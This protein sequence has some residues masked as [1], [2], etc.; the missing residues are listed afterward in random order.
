MDAENSSR[1]GLNGGDCYRFGTIV[2]DA[3][4][5][6]L[7]R[8]GKPQ[9]LEPKAFAV[10]LFLLQHAGE[11]VRHGDLLD[12]VWGHRHVTPGVLTR[13]IAQLRHALDD[14]SQ[15]P[16]YIQTQH[17]LG[18]RFVGELL[19]RPHAGE[20]ES[21][22]PVTAPFDSAPELPAIVAEPMGDTHRI[23]G[24][25][26]IAGDS[27]AASL[28]SARVTARSSREHALSRGLW[29]LAFLLALVLAVWL[30]YRQRPIS[31]ARSTDVSI[32]VLPFASLSDDKSDSYFAE[33][34]AV[35]L[36]DALAG[37][38][39][40]KVA[41]CRTDS[42]CG[43]RGADI[44]KIGKLLGVATVLDAEVRREGKRVRINAHLADTRTGF[45]LWSGSYD[46]EL[47]G[48][49][50]LQNDIA[51]EVVRSLPGIA[52]ANSDALARRLE[53][54]HNIVAYDA[55]LKGVQQ[56]TGR[57]DGAVAIGFFSEAL[58]ADPGFA[59]A[60]A[61]ICRGE[62]ITFESAHDAAAYDRA[63]AA[64]ERAAQMDPQLREVN[65]ALGD[66]HQ[67]R[68]E[69]AQ[70]IVYYKQALEDNALKPAAYLG[71]ARA[72]AAQQ[73]ND[74]AFQY[75]ERARQLRP[76]DAAIYRSL[77]F[78]HYVSGDLPKAIETYKI[79]TELEPNDELTWASYGGLC[80]ASGDTA[81]ASDAFMRSLAIKP[82]YGALIN[83]GTLRF[84]AGVYDE[85]ADLYRRAAEL[86]PSDYRIWG[87]L[88]DALSAIAAT[89]DQAR[90]PYKRA[91]QMAQSY[92]DIKPGD[93]HAIAV[94]AWYR[95]NLGQAQV[96]RDLIARAEAQG[97]EKGEVAFFA[98]QSF[99]LLGDTV[100]AR[101]RIE[102]ARA[103]GIPLAR[104]QASPALRDLIAAAPTAQEQ[105]ETQ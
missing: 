76:G 19:S 74:V 65:L 63:Q 22:G 10:L 21:L 15:H 47:T 9:A 31:P 59:R 100:S 60:Q 61:G 84:D 37:I 32:A 45:T 96:A 48:V 13:A 36:H 56:L 95:A 11:L 62:I 29:M 26:P 53:P 40:L 16:R 24:E 42:V 17:G 87:N 78:Q 86:D 99:A 105:R 81:C 85:A 64:C 12:A 2:V 90:E 102:R 39:G 57:K 104:L 103:E 20:A 43:T 3:A 30:V 58:A 6:T 49:F 46:R 28:L 14:D 50:A 1:A 8:D 101:Q 80:L 33:G 98:A 71:M 97:I 75:F 18:Y 91:A 83:L 4:A 5:Y 66:L 25:P 79:A 73:H 35:E 38:P 23:A 55:Y 51:N 69:S 27:V 68:G 41:A 54:T 82:N 94:L 70:A 44:K 92:I 67:A 77:G 7:T 89:A 72:E 93:A 52:A 34:L 88:G